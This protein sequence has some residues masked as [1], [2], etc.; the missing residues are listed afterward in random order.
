MKWKFWGLQWLVARLSCLNVYLPW[1]SDTLQAPTICAVVHRSLLHRVHMVPVILHLLR[2]VGD[3]HVSYVESRQKEV[4]LA[5]IAIKEAPR[6]ALLNIVRPSCPLALNLQLDIFGEAISVIDS[7]VV[8]WNIS[9][10]MFWRFVFRDFWCGG[11]SKPMPVWW[12]LPQTWLIF[13][14]FLQDKTASSTFQVPVWS[15]GMQLESKG[16]LEFLKSKCPLI[17]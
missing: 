12:S 14:S 3:G 6:K 11:V 2:L 13:M 16:S 10:V 1:S 9:P 5:G 17:F 15:L 7:F 4:R 8:D